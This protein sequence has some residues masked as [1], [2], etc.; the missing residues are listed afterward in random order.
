MVDSVN[1]FPLVVDSTTKK[2]EELP[3]GD[4]LN[5]TGNGISA[6]RD[7]ITETDKK[8]IPIFYFRMNVSSLRGGTTKQSIVLMIIEIASLRSQ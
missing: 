3:S 7:I 2:I 6:V 5:L 4:N 8:C 1:R